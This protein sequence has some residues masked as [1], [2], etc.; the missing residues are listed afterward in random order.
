VPFELGRPFGPPNDPAFQRRVLLAALGLLESKDGPVLLADFPDDDP[1][2]GPNERWHPPVTF[3][4]GAAPADALNR[5]VVAL[6]EPYA[7]SCRERGRTTVGLSGLTPRAAADYLAQWLQPGSMPPSPIPELSPILCLR[8][9]IDDLKAYAMEA[10]IAGGARPSSRQLGDWLWD[11][12]AIGA[13]IRKVRRLL[14][15][16]EDERAKQIAG[17]L[18]VPRLRVEPGD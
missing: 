7:R 12:T 11:A 16:G 4:P 3:R 10:A 1:R 8:F 13:A 2:E 18:L 15:A 17:L 9:A 5:E 6:A 14:L